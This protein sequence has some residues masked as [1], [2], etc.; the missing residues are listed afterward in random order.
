VTSSLDRGFV[1][2]AALSGRALA[3]AARRAGYRPLVA[4]LFGDLDTS[5]AAEAA[6]RLP[7]SLAR[8][9]G[10]ASLLDG[11]DRLSAGRV[12]QG[13]VY[14]SGF[15][16]RPGLIATLAERHDLLGNTAA[17]VRAVK[18]PATLAELC[19]RHDIPHPTLKR[20]TS[21]IGGW[22]EKRAGGSGGAHVRPARPG[23][24]RERYRQLRVDGDPVSALF[25][26]DGRRAVV[27]GFS[28]Q[29]ADPAPGR[30]FRYGGA[31]RPADIPAWLS[32]AMAG[33]IALL[34]PATGLVGMNS[35]DFLVR[36]D[37]FHLLEINPRPGATLDLFAG[38]AGTC[39]HLHVQACRGALPP[40]APVYA[41]AAA[42][43][44]VYAPGRLVLRDD[45]VW[46]A[47]T[48]DRQPPGLPVAADAPLCTV[49]AEAATA[50]RARALVAARAAAILAAA[51]AG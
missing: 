4:D 35:A 37:G 5:E 2:I 16:D 26:A 42:A 23:P 7:G 44:V 48:A 25:L 9:F 8:G 47:W 28:A 10:P 46:P 22:L 29:W 21:D 24:P 18:R 1:L 3:K 41:G 38:A 27:L 51:G 13:L 36:D 6:L 17:T 33:A 40:A 49:L 11:L 19:A 43:A 34:V 39:F 31:V 15:E 20:D 12:P 32:A 45:F 14:G 50:D 30:P